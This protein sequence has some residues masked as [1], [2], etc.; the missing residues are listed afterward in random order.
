DLL[1]RQDAALKQIPEVAS[2]FGKAGRYETSTDPSPLS[3]IEATI[4]LKPRRDWRGGVTQEMLLNDLDRAVAVP[5]L[6]RAWTK[7]VRG[8]IDMLSTGI[9][10]QVGIKIFGRDLTAIEDVGR[11]LEAILAR[12]PGTRSAYAER[13]GGG[14][15][16][17]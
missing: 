11:R 16:I 6:N 1:V 4:R 9:R 13:I 5:G 10:T 3:M 8:R 2:V 12:V 7:P 17:D 15:Y 14:S